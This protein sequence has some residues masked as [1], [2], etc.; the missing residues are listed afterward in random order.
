MSTVDIIIDLLAEQVKV[1]KAQ[2]NA[3][4]EFKKDLKFKGDDLFALIFALGYKIK[5]KFNAF[6][7][8]LPKVKTIGELAEF[9]NGRIIKK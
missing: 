2:L 6:T 5:F 1:P 9:I 8:D 7:E 4:T 3:N